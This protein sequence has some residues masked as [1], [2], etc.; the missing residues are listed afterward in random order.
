MRSFHGFPNDIRWSF[1]RPSLPDINW[2]DFF[3]QYTYQAIQGLMLLL[4]GK[5][6]QLTM[7]VK[8]PFD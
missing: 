8:Q 6:D 4:V 2:I 3:Y 1:E 7:L 5:N